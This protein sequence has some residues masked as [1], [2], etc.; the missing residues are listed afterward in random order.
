MSRATRWAGQ[1]AAAA[2]LGVLAGCA[3]APRS[4]PPTRNPDD[5]AGAA[6]R[7]ER[8]APSG[9]TV[10]RPAARWVGVEWSELPGW[11][12]EWLRDWFPAFR[13]GCSRP[14]PAW[15]GVCAAALLDGV[16]DLDAA[17]A[18]QWL[19]QR[20]Q[21]FRVESLDGNA[22][23]MVT[24]YYEPLLEASRV[25]RPGYEVPI[26]APPVGSRTTWTR[27][28]IDTLPPA[29]TGLGGREIAW[30]RDRLDALVLQ[31][32]GSGRLAITEADGS[33]R[34]VRVA[35]AAHNNQPYQSV[36]RWLI[37]RGELTLARASWPGIKDWARRNPQRV[38]EMMWSN[39]RVVFFREEAL[40]DPSVG[41]RGAAGVP[42]TPGRS[43]A[44]D[45]RSVPYGTPVWLDTTEP[46]SNNPLRRLVVAQDTGTAIVGAV[47]ADYFWGWG[48]AAEASAG[49]MKQ[50]LRMWVLWPLDDSPF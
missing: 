49:R 15:Q 40:P 19:Q 11:S 4:G 45:P 32:Q 17:A 13:R 14:A 1:A 16:A 44:V 41:P 38:D 10:T 25:R 18:R 31:I 26:Y 8:S 48:D 50:R 47:R 9:P 37:D 22:D 28:E 33:R 20:L 27:R 24:G 2:I 42:L 6:V 36:G 21:P 29:Q 5:A 12:G 39:P 30:L 43:I 7:P 46:L 3:S 35:F 23:G 34:V